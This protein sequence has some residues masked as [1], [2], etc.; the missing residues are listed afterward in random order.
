MRKIHINA[1][2]LNKTPF[3]NKKYLREQKR[4]LKRKYEHILENG[5]WKIKNGAKK[6][7]NCWVDE[8]TTVG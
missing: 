4:A 5:Y 1:L 8:K 3:M 6:I 2:N 7:K